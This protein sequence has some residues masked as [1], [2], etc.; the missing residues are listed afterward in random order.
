MGKDHS[1]R[2]DRPPPPQ[3]APINPPFF[4]AAALN[5]MSLARAYRNY[6]SNLS[7]SVLL[8]NEPSWKFTVLNNLI[9]HKTKFMI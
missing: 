9:E 5:F 4:Y 2:E 3:T 7:N 1:H 8:D 6:Y